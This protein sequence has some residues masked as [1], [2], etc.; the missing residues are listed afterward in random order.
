MSVTA[1]LRGKMAIGT[2]L[3]KYLWKRK[4]FW[5]IPAMFVILVFAILIVVGSATGVGPFIYTLF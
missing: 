1:Q 3:L 2:E 5:L 4:L